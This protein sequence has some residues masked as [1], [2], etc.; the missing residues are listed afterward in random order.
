[1]VAVR[2]ERGRIEIADEVPGR[3]I[4]P[5]SAWGQWTFDLR[6]RRVVGYED[7]STQGRTPCDD[8]ARHCRGIRVIV[9]DHAVEQIARR[10]VVQHNI[11]ICGSTYI[12]IGD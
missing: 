7:V 12:L 6:L 3:R 5:N 11:S 4:G 9:R 10:A 8:A 1:M 2:R